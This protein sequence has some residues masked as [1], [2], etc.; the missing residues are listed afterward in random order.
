MIFSAS[1]CTAPATSRIWSG[2]AFAKSFSSESRP[3]LR[4]RIAFGLQSSWSSCLFRSAVARSAS[5]AAIRPPA[6]VMVAGWTPKCRAA[7]ARPSTCAMAQASTSVS[8]GRTT[9]SLRGFVFFCV[10]DADS[11]LEPPLPAGAGRRRF[12]DHRP[13]PLCDEPPFELP[14]CSAP[15][16]GGGEVELDADA[17]HG[18]RAYPRSLPKSWQRLACSHVFVCARACIRCGAILKCSTLCSL[19]FRVGRCA[20][21]F[22]EAVPAVR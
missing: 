7:L 10:I 5:S 18:V 12:H 13:L 6:R 2:F 3:A 17:A 14:L 16:A 8:I 21:D 11:D 4:A 15:E 1:R 22:R 19:F 20:C 9:R